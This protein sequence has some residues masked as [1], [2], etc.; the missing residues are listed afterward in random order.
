MMRFGHLAELPFESQHA[1]KT[2]IELTLP[3]LCGFLL[4]FGRLVETPCGQIRPFVLMGSS[5]GKDPLPYWTVDLL[6][7]RSGDALH[8]SAIALKAVRV[9]AA[10]DCS[11][12]L[13]VNLSK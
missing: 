3:N 6:E 2:F 12:S 5:S 1:L 8:R 7:G 4:P 11:C 10:Q 13:P 9:I